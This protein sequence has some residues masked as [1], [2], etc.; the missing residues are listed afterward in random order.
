MIHPNYDRNYVRGGGLV[1]LSLRPRHVHGV[2]G[3]SSGAVPGGGY[4]YYT[5]LIEQG[6]TSG[7]NAW[8]SCMASRYT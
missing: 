1:N 8:F 6:G 4:S 2:N 7:L 3:T 5:G